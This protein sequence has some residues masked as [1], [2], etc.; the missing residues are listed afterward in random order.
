MRFPNGKHISLKFYSSA[1][2]RRHLCPVVYYFRHLMQTD[3][4]FRNVFC[5]VSLCVCVCVLTRSL[6]LSLVLSCLYLFFLPQPYFVGKKNRYILR[7][8]ADLYSDR[9]SEQRLCLNRNPM[10]SIEIKAILSKSKPSFSLIKN[11]H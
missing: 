7:L 11:L 10:H 4:E 2:V 9:K 8:N 1:Y 5:V 6:S 3:L